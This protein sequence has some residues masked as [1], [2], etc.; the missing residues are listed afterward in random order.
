[1]SDS[2]T[3]FGLAGG[4][5]GVE[6]TTPAAGPPPDHTEGATTVGLPE[7]V[8]G[9]PPGGGRVLSAGAEPVPREAVPV[10]GTPV[11]A[12]ESCGNSRSSGGGI[13]VATHGARAAISSEGV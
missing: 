1:S 6:G 12:G 7:R 10:P 3:P 8:E 13:G 2:Q 11:A 4:G 9:A 5:N